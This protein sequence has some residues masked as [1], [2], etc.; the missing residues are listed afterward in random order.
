MAMTNCFPVYSNSYNFRTID[1][2][3]LI[4]VPN[5]VELYNGRMELILVPNDVELY[6][7]RMELILVPNDAE[8]PVDSEMHSKAK[9][10][11]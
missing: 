8:V 1:R 2:M 5:D 4:L 11:E 9:Y 6:N 3:E 10:F 7:G